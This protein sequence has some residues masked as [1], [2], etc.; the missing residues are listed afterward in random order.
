MIPGSRIIPNCFDGV[1]DGGGGDPD[2]EIPDAGFTQVTATATYT[3][4]VTD[5][6]SAP[7][8]WYAGFWS[9]A[10]GAGWACNNSTIG[11]QGTDI[12]S[13]PWNALR[14]SI[15][16]SITRNTTIPMTHKSKHFT[17][18]EIVR[19]GTEI[20]L[21]GTAGVCYNYF[22][23]GGTSFETFNTS[24]NYIET[25][26]GTD[27]QCCDELPYF[28]LHNIYST[29]GSSSRSCGAPSYGFDYVSVATYDVP[30]LI[31]TIN[32]SGVAIGPWDIQVSGS[33]VMTSSTGLVKTYSGLLSSVASQ[34]NSDGYFTASV[35]GN[36]YAGSVLTS[37][38]EPGSAS[39]VTGSTT[40]QTKLIL[41]RAGTPLTP[42]STQA[43]FTGLV[44]SLSGPCSLLFQKDQGY[45]DTEEGLLAWIAGEF[46]SPVLDFP[47]SSGGCGY[48]MGFGGVC[49]VGGQFSTGFPGDD[50]SNCWG[51]FFNW[52][53][54]GPYKGNGTG[55]SSA[56]SI[57]IVNYSLQH[58]DCTFTELISQP[59]V[60][61]PPPFVTCFCPDLTN[62]GQTNPCGSTSGIPAVPG[63]IG[64][65][66]S[67]ASWY[68]DGPGSS[69]CIGP[70]ICG[71]DGC[72]CLN[73]GSCNDI[74]TTESKTYSINESIE[75]SFIL[76]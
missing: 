18:G 45:P 47:G 58:Y 70:S 21:C 41:K 12:Y 46:S 15:N 61:S 32:A 16:Q 19:P 13:N 52:A 31:L 29:G 76:S 63:S 14:V 1:C 60:V 72:C 11:T 74:T 38:F 4:S 27:I 22:F 64:G 3:Y 20:V 37:D 33:I 28:I 67:C 24:D 25:E 35:P 44:T 40:C 75:G 59:I 7:G 69:C 71:C 36:V 8:G 39:V 62:S 34:I 50:P 48:G 26:Q 43:G 5:D 51:G 6:F 53:G 49:C 56:V 17:S 57:G 65:I 66:P 73:C 23:S 54:P 68:C 30:G 42:S 10:Q 2:I 55:T 9:K